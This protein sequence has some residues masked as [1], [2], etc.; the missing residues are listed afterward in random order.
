MRISIL[1]ILSFIT[2][3]VGQVSFTDINASLSGVAASSVAW[4]DYDNDGDLDLLLTGLPYSSKIYRNDGS[5]TFTNTGISLTGVS[6]S[7]SS[8][9]DYDNDGDLDILLTGAIDNSDT[10]VSK[11]YRNDGSNT[12]VEL[13]S[14]SLT[15]IWYG[16]AAWGDYDNDND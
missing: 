3:L 12:F 15:G 13:T 8:W 6:R 7:F 5:D 4:G 16:S 9:G 10:K 11:I 2:V 14:V 1:S